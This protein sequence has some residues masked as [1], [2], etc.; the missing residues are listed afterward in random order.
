M[1]QQRIVL[2]NTISFWM[3]ESKHPV[4]CMHCGIWIS[5]RVRVEQEDQ[6]LLCISCHVWL[7]RTLKPKTFSLWSFAAKWGRMCLSPGSHKLALVVWNVALALF[8]PVIST[9]STVFQCPAV[10][11]LEFMYPYLLEMSL[12]V[13]EAHLE[14]EC[15][16]CYYVCT[17]RIPLA[18][19]QSSLADG[20]SAFQTE[21]DWM[22]LLFSFD[23][24]SAPRFSCLFCFY[25]ASGFIL[26]GIGRDKESSS[27]SF[28]SFGSPHTS[29]SCSSGNMI[30]FLIYMMSGGSRAH[31]SI[32]ATFSSNFYFFLFVFL[33]VSLQLFF[34]IFSCG[35]IHF[36]LLFSWFQSSIFYIC[37]F[38]RREGALISFYTQD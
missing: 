4:G 1:L 22:G 21:S 14:S 34:P 12:I 33:A 37:L 23:F 10:L 29:P 15:V 32:I 18:E 6:T 9:L 38:F 31:T 27:P 28:L 25:N 16:G 2:W 17:D 5:F 36:K 11:I 30:C 26:R 8:A 19:F 24:P 13:E 7:L 3:R 35:Q 20:H